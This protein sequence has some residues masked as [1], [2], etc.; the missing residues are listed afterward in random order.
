MKKDKNIKLF[1]LAPDYNIKEVKEIYGPLLDDTMS[2]KEYVGSIKKKNKNIAIS[3]GYGTGKSSLIKTYICHSEYRDKTLFVSLSTYINNSFDSENN[4]LTEEDYNKLEKSILQQIIYTENPSLFPYSRIE[5]ID[6][7]EKDLKACSALFGFVLSVIFIILY[8]VSHLET[9]K[10][11][12]NSNYIGWTICI[13]SIFIFQ[14]LWFIS[15][16]I[17][18]KTNNLKIEIKLEKIKIETSK[19]NFTLDEN[20]DELINFFKRTNNEVVV[21]EDIDRI[22]NSGRI[23]SKLK[24]INEIINSAIKEKSIIFIYAIKDDLFKNSELRTKFYDIVIPIIPYANHNNFGDLLYNYFQKININFD[25]SDTNTIGIFAKNTRMI[26]DIV[27]EFIIF[28]NNLHLQDPKI[29]KMLLYLCSYKVFY[30]NRFDKLLKN[31]GIIS[32]YLSPNFR[33]IS[34]ERAKEK[35]IS[36]VDNDINIEKEK[37]MN[38]IKEPI[39]SIHN[40]IGAELATSNFKFYFEENDIEVATLN[41]IYTN[42][43]KLFLLEGK[44][45]YLLINSKRIEENEIFPESKK[46]FFSN[47]KSL[48]RYK[49]I[50]KYES[51]KN[52]LLQASFSYLDCEFDKKF[53][54]DKIKGTAFSREEAN[55]YNKLN[56]FEEVMIINDVLNEQIFSLISINHA[57]YMDILDSMLIRNIIMNN[58]TKWDE[59]VCSPTD[60]I[61]K[62]DFN[63]F[64]RD[65]TCI[66]GLYEEIIGQ[67]KSEKTE[68]I[69]R[70]IETH[71]SLE[72]FERIRKIE[73][74]GVHFIKQSGLLENI[75]QELE[76]LKCPE[77]TLDYYL[78]RIFEEFDTKELEKHNTNIVEKLSNSQNIISLL[79]GKYNPNLE[80][81]LI[82]SGV[83]FNENVNFD[84]ENKKMMSLIYKYSLYTICD[85]NLQIIFKSRNKKYEETKIITSIMK[86]PIIYAYVKS[87]ESNIEQFIYM[88]HMLQKKGKNQ[89]DSEKEIVKFLNDIKPN[90]ELFQNF[91]KFEKTSLKR[92]SNLNNHEYYG[93]LLQLDKITPNWSN[94]Y[95]LFKLITGNEQNEEI[96][97]FISN[98][99]DTLGSSNCPNNKKKYIAENIISNQS[100]DNTCLNKIINKIVK[101]KY[102]T[103]EE[104][105]SNRLK[106]FIENSLLEFKSESEFS[107]LC[108]NEELSFKDKAKALHDSFEYFAG[109][110]MEC[111]NSEILYEF[112]K[113]NEGKINQ[114]IIDFIYLNDS[115]INDEIKDKLFSVLQ[116]DE[117]ISVKPELLYDLLENVKQSTDCK[118]EFVLN[119]QTILEEYDINEIL[120][121]IGGCWLN[122]TRKE[123]HTFIEKSETNEK[124]L[125]ILQ[126]KKVCNYKET[127]YKFRISYYK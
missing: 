21:F 94:I 125:K 25:L 70:Q 37:Y 98:N 88:L 62:L 35:I 15:Y 60:V 30:P 47:I 121:T 71:L 120:S 7:S 5:R 74:S 3:G 33:E 103:I 111:L 50:Q 86:D 95:D 24:D 72:K 11:L 31:E 45:I 4:D 22:K 36:I 83:C 64:S 38:D 93:I 102:H 13:L 9:L 68:Q 56:E 107:K 73:E 28:N 58:E 82:N 89:Q 108:I 96:P 91:I 123:K 32:F 124:F 59:H 100:I 17:L 44:K 99:A 110:K 52:K 114:N 77:E 75:C 87:K 10:K 109:K 80:S 69:I 113:I 43:E 65:N 49:K 27:N 39:D 106:V 90:V 84:L 92:I 116:H 97:K 122:I 12:G 105:P 8:F 40:K 117:V 63:F 57:S 79:E 2:E 66:K 26:K 55:E 20:I 85:R 48:N 53:L 126:E 19:E 23:F 67:R 101:K 76:I 104:I 118:V 16:Y 115:L 18:R 6:K 51:D 46:A 29:K 119:H 81:K 54:E 42:Y 41:E 34:T 14:A 127:K 61:K 112:L 1:S 78:Y